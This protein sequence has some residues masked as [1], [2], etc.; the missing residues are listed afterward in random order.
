VAVWAS[1]TGTALLLPLVSRNLLQQAESLSA[2]GWLS[3][4]Y[5]ALLS[6]VLANT[7]YFMLVGLH[8]V[9]RLSV[10]LYLIPLVS[11]TGGIILLRESLGVFT[12]AGGVVLLL[13]VTLVTWRR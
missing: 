12:V 10:Q 11:V 2:S 8:P 7:I 6:T 9:S 5:L 3:V 13:A 4:L 1:L